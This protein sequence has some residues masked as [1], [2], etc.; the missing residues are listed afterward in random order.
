[1]S[2]VFF[3]YA[4]EIIF[5]INRKYLYNCIYWTSFLAETTVNTFRHIYIVSCCT[6]RSISSL[7]CF[8]SNSLRWTDCLAQFTCD[9][10]FLSWGIS[11][12]INYLHFIYFILSISDLNLCSH[13]R[14]YSNVI[15]GS[16]YYFSG[17][18][19][20]RNYNT[21]RNKNLTACLC[22][23]WEHLQFFSLNKNR[24]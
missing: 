9:A 10:P 22:I 19:L 2:F 3:F 16:S 6:T 8:N 24:N 20:Q 12:G 15:H 21:L 18:F 13:L 5:R 7:F 4:K 17:F 11:Y 14:G 23:F 1:M